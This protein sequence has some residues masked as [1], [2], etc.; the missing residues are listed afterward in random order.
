M[1]ESWVMLRG[2]LRGRWILLIVLLCVVALGIVELW[3]PQILT[4]IARAIVSG[5][6]QLGSWIRDAANSWNDFFK[7]LTNW[8][9]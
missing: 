4:A 9:R 7:N 6:V 1:Q 3:Q 8:N 2:S 5:I